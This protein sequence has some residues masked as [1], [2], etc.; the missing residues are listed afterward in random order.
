MKR[1]V[2]AFTLIELLVV[3]AIIAILAA[4]LFPVF[5]QAREKARQASC[6]SNQKQIGLAILQYV[7]D[8]DETY[9]L[10]ERNAA[11]SE[12]QQITNNGGTIGADNPVTWH[13]SV[14]P[15]VKN[16]QQAV[17]NPWLGGLEM[18]GGI[19]HC[20]SYP[21]QKPREYAANNHIIAGEGAFSWNGNTP[22][23]SAALAVI[24]S[25]ANKVLVVE[26]GYLGNDPDEQRRQMGYANFCA[27]QWCYA[28]AGPS[29]TSLR[30]LTNESDN[31]I[32]DNWP[33]SSIVPR[34]RHNRTTNV[35]YA[36]GHVKSVARGNLSGFANWCSQ[37]YVNSGVGP[38]AQD[39]YPYNGTNPTNG[40]GVCA[41]YDR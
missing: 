30:D 39:W 41:Q 40:P 2:A 3:I 18:E 14:N 11:G 37:I 33:Q 5:A 15:Y 34:Y 27:E 20:P 16:G 26:V 31:G 28:D 12:L 6:L 19:W 13:F 9:P 32:Y 22:S 36:D 29:D 38:S 21:V 17:F 24:N 35:L 10:K 8:Y 25:P 7:Q 4:I 23:P 1:T